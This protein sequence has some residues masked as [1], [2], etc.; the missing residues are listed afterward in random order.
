M[1]TTVGNSTM[2]PAASQAARPEPIPTDTEK[3][4]RNSVTTCSLPP[5]VKE[6]SGGNSDR[7]S[8]PTSQNQLA[9]IAPHHSR[10]SARTCLM[11]DAGGDEDVAVDGKIGRRLGGLGNEQAR[12]PARQRGQYHQPGE[13]DRTAVAVGGNAGDDGAEQNGEKGAGFDQRIAGRQLA[14][15]EKVGQNAV[16]DRTEQRRERAEQKHRDEQQAERMKGKARDG[17]HGGADLGELDALRDE[18][19]VVT[20]GQ[21]AAEP[22]KKE[23]RGDQ[24]RAGERDQ[25]RRIGAGNLEQNDEDQRRLEKIVAEGRKELAP[26]QRREAA[27]RHQ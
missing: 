18:G 3:I 1:A 16:F 27:R 22:G 2:R 10:G 25:N 26:E 24:R 12:G 11:S 21:L 9:T 14:A 20:V 7:T 4:V 13:M 17:D 19:L 8:A 5:M 23:E 15:F 6:T